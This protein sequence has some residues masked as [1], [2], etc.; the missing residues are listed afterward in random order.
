MLRLPKGVPEVYSSLPP[1]HRS[2]I[3]SSVKIPPC[4]LKHKRFPKSE[5]CAWKRPLRPRS[6]SYGNAIDSERLPPRR[7]EQSPQRSAIRSART[8]TLYASF[9]RDSYA[10]TRRI[11]LHAL[12]HCPPSYKSFFINNFTMSKIF[13]CPRSVTNHASNFHSVNPFS[14]FAHCSA[15]ESRTRR[16][17][18]LPSARS[19]L[20]IRRDRPNFPSMCIFL[21][22]NDR[23]G[24]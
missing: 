18:V 23:P 5:P 7:P 16:K 3:A 11:M 12:A 8:R 24:Q 4:T 13:L 9:C 1:R 10:Y 17:I 15:S 22:L 19:L 6:R 20:V 2:T 14:R 21:Y